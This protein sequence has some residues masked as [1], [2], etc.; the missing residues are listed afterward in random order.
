MVE[1]QQIGVFP[2]ILANGL[3]GIIPV[4]I[5]L[6]ASA[7][8]M[9]KTVKSRACVPYW[10]YLLILLINAVM[11]AACWIYAIYAV[12]ECSVHHDKVNPFMLHI[13]GIIVA[14]R[15]MALEVAL[16][17]L[18]SVIQAKT[19]KNRVPH[20]IALVAGVCVMGATIFAWTPMMDLLAS[21]LV[22]FLTCPL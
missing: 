2:F 4:I 8:F 20:I 12:R 22:R 3:S 5:G 19:I 21:F 18:S 17:A 1:F 14:L 10:A 16:L 15:F 9:V 7:V 11:M 6:I 13:G